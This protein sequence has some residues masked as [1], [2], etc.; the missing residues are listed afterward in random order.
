MCLREP[1]QPAIVARSH[2]Q[3]SMFIP[4][5]VLVRP[6]R[7]MLEDAGTIDYGTLVFTSK[8]L[9]VCHVL[10]DEARVFIWRLNNCINDRSILDRY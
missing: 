2:G 6:N 5:C 3:Q 9:K 8:G 4:H 10:V 1:P 7:Q